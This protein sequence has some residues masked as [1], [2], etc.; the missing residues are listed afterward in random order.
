MSLIYDLYCRVYQKFVKLSAYLMPWRVPQVVEGA[1]A[2]FAIPYLLKEKGI[3]DVLIVTDAALAESGLLDTLRAKL[4]EAEINFAI[5]DKVVPNPNIENIEEG[6]TAYKLSRSQAIIAF[7]GGSCIDCAKVIGARVVRPNKSIDKM[8][9][10]LKI[11]KKLPFLVAVPT[12]AGTGSETTVVAVVSN[13]KTHEK[14][15]ISDPALIPH[16]AVLDPTLLTGLPPHI[17]ATTGMDTLTHA[18]EAYIGG[19]NT[20]FTKKQAV[21]CVKLVFGNLKKSYEQPKDVAA[22]FAMQK[23]AFSGGL[24]FTRAFIGYVH[25]ISHT[26]SGFYNTPHGLANAVILPH[27]LE[28]YGEF[29]YK[30]LAKLADI[31]GIEDGATREG[32]AKAFIAAVRQLNSDMKIPDTIDKIKAEHIPE[33]ARRAIKEANPL[34]PVPEIWDVTRFEK[35]YRLIGGNYYR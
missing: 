8:K 24:A 2:T 4:S 28:E 33:M 22:R 30:P 14:Y 34:Y 9:G 10:L 15:T 31:V 16:V 3:S 20:R 1:D 11:R 6:L 7:G 17:T 27:V 12:T 13:N 5:Y 32:R 21:E 26:L 18:I 35:I 25:A 19:S 29:A 23:A